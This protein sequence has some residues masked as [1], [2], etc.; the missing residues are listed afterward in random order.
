MVSSLFTSRQHF[1]T[2]LCII[3]HQ[4]LALNLSTTRDCCV[5]TSDAVGLSRQLSGV[6]WSDTYGHDAGKKENRFHMVLESLTRLNKV[7]HTN[8][9]RICK[10]YLKLRS[11]LSTEMYGSL[12]TNYENKQVTKLT[13]GFGF[14]E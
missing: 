1:G 5:V 11:Y 4:P 14:S 12:I 8:V 10:T 13:P 9:I 3:S 6:M 2:I 7:K